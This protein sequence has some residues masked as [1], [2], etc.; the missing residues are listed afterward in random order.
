LDF[1]FW[2]YDWGRTLIESQIQIGNPKSKMA[3]GPS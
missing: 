1:R 3:V 2:I